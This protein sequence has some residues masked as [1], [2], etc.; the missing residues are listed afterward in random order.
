MVT[1]QRAELAARLTTPMA[2]LA[3]ACARVWGQRE[4]IDAEL[5]KRFGSIPHVTFAY[6]LD[7]RARQVSSNMTKKG[8]QPAD[9]GRDRS[10]RPYMRSANPVA[11]DFHLSE[12]YISLHARRPSVTAI[13]VVRDKGMLLGFVG[14]DFDLR[15]LPNVGEMYEEPSA[16]RQMKGDPAIRGSLFQ[17]CR[18]DSI[19][20]QHI[21]EVMAV[22][23]E[24]V[25]EHGVFHTKLHFSSSRATIWLY[26]DP[27]NYR[28]LEYEALCDPDV[29]LVYPRR[30]Y[31]E[32]A[33]V[34]EKDVRRI[35]D[36]W[37]ELR[38]ADENIYLRSG[39]LNIMNGRIALNFSCDGTHYLQHDEFLNRNNAFWTSITAV[40][41]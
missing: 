5:Q 37:R 7:T 22:V 36:G 28:L 9:F 29:C 35:L 3:A 16:W 2:A 11:A 14:A 30:P 1:T 12:A 27:Y 6:A 10:H 13:Q 26:D 18:V 15:N 25:R 20:D 4:A 32:G 24:L 33:R 34:P 21:D 31:P 38:F 17:S 39:S 8:L 19:A 41:Q 40:A 23:E